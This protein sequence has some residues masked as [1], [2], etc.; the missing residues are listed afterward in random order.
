MRGSGKTGQ[1]VQKPNLRHIA[2]TVGRQHKLVDFLIINSPVSLD[3][4]LSLR[5]VST[6]LT[7][8]FIPSERFENFNSFGGFSELYVYG[9]NNCALCVKYTKKARKPKNASL[10]LQRTLSMNECSPLQCLNSVV[11]LSLQQTL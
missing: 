9:F 8:A 6:H 7:S 3:I 1:F 10:L 2:S 11:F 4:A 5:E